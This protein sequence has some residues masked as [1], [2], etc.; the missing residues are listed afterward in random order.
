MEEE[1]KDGIKKKNSVGEKLIEAKG[2]FIQ[3]SVRACALGLS[4]PCRCT[5][6]Q[7]SS[8]PA[9]TLSCRT[10]VL[11]VVGG[12]SEIQNRDAHGTFRGSGGL[13]KHGRNPGL[14]RCLLGC[15]LVVCAL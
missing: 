14:P 8:G 5:R 13:R 4:A 9:L 12:K 1:I 3:C 7:L 2:N 15:D 6:V 11:G 10:A